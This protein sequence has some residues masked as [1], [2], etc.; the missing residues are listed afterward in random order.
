LQRRPVLKIVDPEYFLMS[1]VLVPLWRCLICQPAAERPRQQIG[2]VCLKADVSPP[3]EPMAA[4]DGLSD[5]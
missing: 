2:L 1:I 4:R 3:R 5:L